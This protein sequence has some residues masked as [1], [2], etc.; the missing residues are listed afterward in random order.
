MRLVVSTA[1]GDRALE[2]ARTLVAQRLAACVNVLP[3]A[4]SVYVWEGNVCEDDESVLLLKTT[5]A[6]AAALS[7]RLKELHPYDVPE[8]VCLEIRE[9][10]GNPAY[11]D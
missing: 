3:G 6:L 7:A 9:G 4:R 11:L 2:L 1:P 5:D 10:E 8:I